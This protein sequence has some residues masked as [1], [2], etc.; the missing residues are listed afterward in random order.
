[1]AGL[2]RFGPFVKH[3]DDY[4]SLEATD[5]LFTINLERALALLAAPKRS[6]RQAA[7]RVIRKIDVPDGGTAL[8]VLEGR[9]GPYVTDGELNASI[10]KGA[11]PAT[12]SLEDA[13]ALLEARRNVAGSPRDRRRAASGAARGRRRPGRSDVPADVPQDEGQGEDRRRRPS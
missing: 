1:M 13:R 11:D 9:Y 10:P 2:G 8:Q 6:A 5:D 4:R 12:L 3:G 7:K